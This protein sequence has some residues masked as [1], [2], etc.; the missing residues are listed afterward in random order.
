MDIEHLGSERKRQMDGMARPRKCQAP[1]GDAET[2]LRGRARSWRGR[3]LSPL[4]GLRPEKNVPFHVARGTTM[5]IYHVLHTVLRRPMTCK[6][7]FE[8]AGKWR[9]AACL[10]TKGLGSAYSCDATVV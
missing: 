1:G 5:R 6:N 2:P 8:A 4:H 10:C 3:C 7:D 9:M